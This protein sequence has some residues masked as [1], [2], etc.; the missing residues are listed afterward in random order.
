MKPAFKRTALT[1]LAAAALCMSAATPATAQGIPVHDSSSLIQ[2]IQQV[3]QAVEIINQGKQQIAEAKKLYDDLNGL[4]DIPQLAQQLKTDALREL[5]SGSGSLG[6]YAAGDFTGIGEGRA[7]AQ[8]TYKEILGVLGQGAGPGDER[9]NER[10]DYSARRIATD[11]AL[12]DNIGAA[13]QSRQ[14]GLEQLRERLASASSA[15][16][17]QDLTARLQAESALM[18][19]DAMRL[20]AIDRAIAAQQ[21]ARA[22]KARAARQNSAREEQ[23]YFRGEQ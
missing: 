5:D 11:T 22:A 6:T 9:F 19:N 21:A 17:V 12:A 18:A 16:E 8:Q 1:G 3:K 13:A 10:Y 7:R 2:Q 20:E 14:A 4:T 15:K 23:A